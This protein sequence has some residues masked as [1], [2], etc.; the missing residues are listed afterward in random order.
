MT[1]FNSMNISASALTAQRLRM[2]VVSAN[3][4]NAETTRGQYVNG[5][6]Q[7]YRRKMVSLAPQSGNQNPFS[8]QLSRAMNSSGTIGQGVKA[9]ALVDDMSPFKL[10]YQPEHPDAN[11]EG[12]VSLPNVD[13]LREMVDL[14]SASRSY[15]ANVTTMNASKNM[16]MKALE[17][18]K[19]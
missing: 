18:G 12:Y 11:E 10:I 17:I 1:I 6:W 14:M 3:M 7:P 19:G 9:T 2:D 13:P 16:L 5:E 4:A 15:E 8:A